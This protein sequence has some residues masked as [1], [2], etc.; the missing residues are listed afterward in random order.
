MASAPPIPANDEESKG[1]TVTLSFDELFKE[2]EDANLLIDG[3]TSELRGLIAS[4][5]SEVK[6]IK[7][8]P[9]SEPSETINAKR[10]RTSIEDDLLCPITKDLPFDPVTAE[11]GKQRRVPG[12]F[13]CAYS[14]PMFNRC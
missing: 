12:E 8:P 9:T 6:S 5:S 7:R 4:Q 10:P 11:D 1:R 2:R 13:P 3:S 14:A